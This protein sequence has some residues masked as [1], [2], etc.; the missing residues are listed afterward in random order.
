MFLF[1]YWGIYVGQYIF[2]VYFD[3]DVVISVIGYFYGF[4]YVNFGFVIVVDCGGFGG[5]VLILENL[6]VVKEYKM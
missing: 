6:F 2:S 1:V 3:C 4:W 5:L